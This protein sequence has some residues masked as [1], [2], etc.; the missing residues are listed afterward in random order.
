MAPPY[1]LCGRTDITFLVDGHWSF[2]K[3]HFVCGE[4]THP[5]GEP[6]G[7]MSDTALSAA[8]EAVDAATQKEQR[9]RARTKTS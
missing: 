2:D 7:A 9:R 1:L 3:R 4:C 5:D 6:A 8:R